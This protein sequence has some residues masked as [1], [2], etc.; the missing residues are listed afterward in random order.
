MTAVA[1]DLVRLFDNA[2]AALAVL[3]R[4]IARSTEGREPAGIGLNLRIAR[5]ELAQSAWYLG[6]ALERVEDVIR[7]ERQTSSGHRADQ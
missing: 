2:Y 3:D 4:A 1:G 5:G 6:D 7:R